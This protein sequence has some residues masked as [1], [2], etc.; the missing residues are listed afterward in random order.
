MTRAGRF[1]EAVFTSLGC[2]ITRFSDRF[3]VWLQGDDAVDLYNTL[4]NWSDPRIVDVVLDAYDHVL[5]PH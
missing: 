1:Y 2:T 3:S 4:L 5:E